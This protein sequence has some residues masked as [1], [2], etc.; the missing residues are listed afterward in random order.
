MI[1][2]LEYAARFDGTDLQR[3]FH[4]TQT[5]NIPLCGGAEGAKRIG[6]GSVCKVPADG[7]DPHPFPQSPQ[8]V[9]KGDQFAVVPFQHSK[10]HALGGAFAHAGQGLE[11]FH[12]FGERTGKRDLHYLFTFWIA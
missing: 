11:E 2:S 4:H 12:H 6:T 9:G 5:G 7:T 8:D 3:I 1:D 10:R